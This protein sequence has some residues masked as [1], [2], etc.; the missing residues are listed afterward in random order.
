MNRRF[1]I[2]IILGYFLTISFHVN[3][4]N[5][6]TIDNGNWSSQKNW[7]NNN[8]PPYILP[9]GDTIFIY[10]DI[11][12][13]QNLTIYGVLIIDYNDIL[14]DNG[15]KN[16]SI[17][18]YGKVIVYG[19]LNCQDL[20]VNSNSTLEI[21]G[22]VVVEGT[23]SCSG[24]INIETTQSNTGNLLV[25]GI[26]NGQRSVSFKRYIEADGWH[27]FSS[28]VSN[29]NTNS[30]MGMAVYSYNETQGSWTRHGAN[31]AFQVMKGYDVYLKNSGKTIQFEG[32]FNNGD[33]SINLTRTLNGGLGYNLVGNPYPTTI[34]WNTSNGWNKVN[35]N[36]AIYIWD[37]VSKNI[38]SYVNGIGQNGGTNLIPPTSAFFVICN[39]T[40]GGNLTV[41]NSARVSDIVNFREIQNNDF[42]SITLS[43]NQFKDETI[44]RFQPNTTDNF[45]SDWD[46][47]KMFSFEKT[48]PQLYTIT[49][50]NEY[51]AISSF[52]RPSQS[53]S[54]PLGIYIPADGQ[55][56]FKFDLTNL[57][58]NFDFILEDHFTKEVFNLREGNYTFYSV[59]GTDDSRFTLHVLPVQSVTDITSSASNNET[60][61][62]P[63]IFASGKT[64]NISAEENIPENIAV[65]DI[66][67]R[68][69]YSS[70]AN[71]SRITVESGGV[72]TVLFTLKGRPFSKKIILD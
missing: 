35:V 39:N 10:N 27:Y 50:K 3:S 2:L 59:N 37:P 28:P 16:V 72:Y 71:V 51:L 23:Y 30:F 47:L 20:T 67:G 1:V 29:G 69:I 54:V 56:T 36:N 11:T 33:Y 26:I 42:L 58:E 18:N 44:I 57:N 9:A 41:H 19:I 15:K 48:V 14:A 4:T 5:Y 31:E 49:G 65:V 66:T 40:S 60:V 21:Y 43:G 62:L 13:P 8:I 61:K 63:L 53:I 24:S 45:E 34:N 52:D 55:Y 46:A 12:F 17:N 6:Y 64:I 22:A 70:K 68:I 32:Q 25:K 7:R 38:T